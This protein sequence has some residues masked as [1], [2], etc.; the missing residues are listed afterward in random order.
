ML[1][2]RET[3]E[4]QFVYFPAGQS[5]SGVIERFFCSC[6]YFPLVLSLASSSA[7]FTTLERGFD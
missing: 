6:L 5:L 1:F 4:T 2:P 3:T 7:P